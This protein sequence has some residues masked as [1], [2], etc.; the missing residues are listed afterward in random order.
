M[1]SVPPP[2]PNTGAGDVKPDAQMESAPATE[3]TEDQPQPIEE[4]VPEPEDTFEDIPDDVRNAPVDD[5]N[6]RTRL[7]ENDIKVSLGND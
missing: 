1:S 3:K 6:T 5:V 4:E 7:I 2:N